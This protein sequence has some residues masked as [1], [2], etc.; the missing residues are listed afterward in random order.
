MEIANHQS[1]SLPG[2]GTALLMLAMFLRA[3]AGRL[4]ILLQIV[5]GVLEAYHH[6]H[7]QLRLVAQQLEVLPG[8]IILL[9]I[10]QGQV[11]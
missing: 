6:L 8:L 9:E 11:H 5:L 10:F 7:H 4:L 2:L 1:A 3:Q